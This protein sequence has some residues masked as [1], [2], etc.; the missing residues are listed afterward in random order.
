MVTRHTHTLWAALALAAFGLL[1]CGGSN[2]KA[3]GGGNDSGTQGCLYDEDCPD[4]QLFGCNTQTSTCEPACRTKDDCGAA[5]RGQYAL[6]YCANGLG[7]QCDEGKCVGAL[8]ASDTD[9][10]ATQVCRSGACVTAPAASTVASCQITPDVVVVAAGSP[11]KFWVSSWDSA[12]KPV[13]VK[14]GATWAGVGSAFT[15]TGTG[16][17]VTLTAGA[18]NATLS[19][20]VSASFGSV[21]CKA[22]AII[23]GAAPSGSTVVVVTDEL[24][25]RPVVGAKV[26]ASKADGSAIGEAVTTD[27]SGVAT[28]PLAGATTYSV[29]AF[30]AD[31]SYVTVANY[32][33]S[34]SN[35]ISI[36]TRRNQV[37]KFGGFRGTLTGVPA[38][39][40][41]H[42]GIA[43]MSLAGSITSLSLSQLLG[44]SVPTNVKIG[45][46]SKDGV[47]IPA[48]AYLGFTDSVIKGNIAGQGLAGVCNNGSGA[49]DET[50]IASGACGTR[51]AWVLGG[52]VSLG[53]LP[54]DQLTGGGP[55]D[56]GAILSRI[57]PLFKKFNSTISRDVQFDLQPT[58]VV[59]G[60]YDFSDGGFFTQKDL[61]FAQ[62]PLG[63]SF[64]AKL[65]DL[66][67]FKGA[68]ADG[69][70]LL[71][72]ANVPGRGVVP[73]G[74]GIGV[75]LDSDAKTD[76]QASLPSQGLVQMRMAPTH[77]GI[78]GDEY[79][80]IIAALSLKSINDVSAGIAA[81]AIFPRMANNTLPFDPSGNSP[82][83]FSAQAFPPFPEGA[84]YNYSSTAQGALSGRTFKFGSAT[85][86]TGIDVVRVTFT[87][88]LERRWDVF[89]DPSQ[90]SVTLP[91]PPSTLGDRTFTNGLTS[92]DRST[93][94]VQAL[95]LAADP[96]VP[97]THLSFNSLVE[98]NGHNLDTITNSLTAFSFIDYSRP[99]IAFTTPAASGS[100][101]AKG[102]NV[103]V[104]VKNFNLSTDGAVK[105]SFKLADAPVA[106]CPDQVSATE[107]TPG[108]G[109]VQFALAAA[110][111]GTGL[112]M[113][114]TLVGADQVTALDPAVASSTV[115]T[116]Q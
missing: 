8:C 105:L 47:G 62:L 18:A 41:I 114:A 6:D 94:L 34:G 64:V 90:T 81:S 86:L 21:T 38:T 1:G 111:A 53:D 59:N 17:S 27:T 112:T 40:N 102:S 36:A 99:S 88:A 109:E 76:V 91:V 31:Y 46:F 67:K 110:C 56:V 30:H 60:A 20:A 98:L 61:P 100:T 55:I 54:I 78:E 74:I 24:S 70:L 66:P 71:G 16:A 87:D 82:V 49:P 116:I 93:M 104:Q 95:S 113:T 89:F 11:V 29:T 10:G 97:A 48:G 79:G 28:I 92:G 43:G 58:P 106:T 75:N 77:D 33:A 5:K 108:K 50:K 39:S 107:T 15:G 35:V 7:C 2:S 3:D 83:N 4:P 103:V 52:D 68:Y 9:C 57:I 45:S 23:V 25:G 12:S 51:A 42:A 14:E 101:V 69:A 65:P 72:G 32:S 22:K 26:V 63:F 85:T 80:V 73:L 115:V 96:L 19:D 37:D 44:P 13:V 84:K